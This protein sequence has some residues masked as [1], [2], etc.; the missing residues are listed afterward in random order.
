MIGVNRHLTPGMREDTMRRIQRIERALGAVLVV[1]LTLMGCAAARP[2]PGPTAA[3]SPGGPTTPAQL[4]AECRQFAK[5]F[6]YAGRSVGGRS[7]ATVLLAPLAIGIGLAG[8]LTMNPQGLVL[9]VEAPV[10]MIQWTAEAGTQNAA[11]ARQLGQACEEGGGPD[12]VAASKAVRDLA[13]VRLEERNTADAIRLYRDALGILDRAGA[14]D[15]EDAA[16]TA[17]KLVRLVDAATPAS[18]EVGVLYQRVVGILEHGGS[19]RSGELAAVLALY[20]ESLRA[21]GRAAEAEVLEAR[22]VGSMAADTERAEEPARQT[23]AAEPRM[24]I[25]GISFLPS[26]EHADLMVL[27][28]LNV[29]AAAAG[30]L[31]RI[32]AVGCREDGR[33]HAVHLGSATTGGADVL[34]LDEQER[35][36]EARI[37]P[38]LVAGDR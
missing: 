32:V 34:I 36:L 8:F 38:A 11:Q 21:A 24:S 10:K 18:P 4:A 31:G 1:S 16:W 9:A 29:D 6:D 2:G 17:L 30:H 27:D 28:R 3:G 20:A 15:S 7:A 33:I 13:A 35:D 5:R 23:P 25:T 19:T 12:T 37:R 14:G 22:S 26:C